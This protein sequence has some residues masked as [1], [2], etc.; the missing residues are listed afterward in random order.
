[1]DSVFNDFKKL[2]NNH[3][4]ALFVGAGVSISP[5][6]SLPSAIELIERTVDIVAPDSYMSQYL[7]SR[8]R[9][10]RLERIL[11]IVPTLVS[12]SALQI[13]NCG[14]P[15]SLHFALASALQQGCVVLTTNFDS[16]IEKALENWEPFVY[17]HPTHYEDLK[18]HG[19]P[20]SLIKLHGS[21]DVEIDGVSSVASTIEKIAFGLS[22]ESTKILKKVQD[23]YTI[24][25]LG[26]SGSDV[27]DLYPWLLANSF[28]NGFFWF[29][30]SSGE[31][32][33]SDINKWPEDNATHIVKAQK[34]IPLEGST[35]DFLSSIFP[36]KS[37]ISHGHNSEFYS[38]PISVPK[39]AAE[40][41][42]L[43]LSKNAGM[44]VDVST[45]SL[46]RILISSEFSKLNSM[47]SD[48][49][50][51]DGL[52]R[53][54]LSLVDRWKSGHNANTHIDWHEDYQ[55]MAFKAAI[56]SYMVKGSSMQAWS[57]LKS[58]LQLACK[59]LQTGRGLSRALEIFIL[60]AEFAYDDRSVGCVREDP[61]LFLELVWRL[62]EDGKYEFEK[63]YKCRVLTIG[64][65]WAKDRG[66][67]EKALEFIREA[68]HLSQSLHYCNEYYNSL[69]IYAQIYAEM[70]RCREALDRL[71]EIYSH[72]TQSD[73]FYRRAIMLSSVGL[74]FAQLEEHNKA[75]ECMEEALQEIHRLGADLNAPILPM[76]RRLIMIYWNE[77]RDRCRAED[78]LHTAANILRQKQSW[79]GVFPPPTIEDLWLSEAYNA[80]LN[81]TDIPR[82]HSMLGKNGKPRN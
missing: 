77:R 35:K 27:F 5:P 36:Q 76:L 22:E 40:V 70:G 45:A 16:H 12:N 51:L 19:L 14:K 41:G 59:D 3:K 25:V 39:L 38:H 26:Y 13:L 21:L 24:V 58:G 63:K 71:N 53:H 37:P 55:L 10:I 47:G 52:E 57:V 50:P 62:V 48:L 66:E 32:R 9:N 2:V 65:T 73:D 34:G 81:G 46:Q 29:R 69:F 28:S 17:A 60:C 67:H 11:S 31:P 7:M 74:R 82:H 78:H 18:R 79:M 4:L 20:G 23:K 80:M 33:V 44:P 8:V 6:S 42:F 1:M 75:I 30:H 43:H 56:G 68:K 64:A 54:L 49:C 61:G 72:Y 15:N